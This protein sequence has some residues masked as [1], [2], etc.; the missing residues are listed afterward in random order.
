VGSRRQDQEYAR[1]AQAI[2]FL[3]GMQWTG[4]I[5]FLTG[6]VPAMFDIPQQWP[7]STQNVL[8]ATLVGG[9]VVILAAGFGKW[10]LGVKDPRSKNRFRRGGSD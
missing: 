1:F 10:S 4:V 8:F 3:N 5:L 6:F 2:R 9:V 7:E